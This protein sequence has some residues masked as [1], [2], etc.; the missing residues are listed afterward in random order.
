ML[1][2]GNE[3]ISLS[4]LV[5]ALSKTEKD[6]SW[7]CWVTEK[8]TRSI[9][10][11]TNEEYQSQPLRFWGKTYQKLSLGELAALAHT[12]ID[13]EIDLN[14]VNF[15]MLFLNKTKVVQ[16]LNELRNHAIEKRNLPSLVNLTVPEEGLH[17]KKGKIK[18]AASDLKIILHKIWYWFFDPI[19][20]IS[21][22]SK[23]SNRDLVDKNYFNSLYCEVVGGFE[24]SEEAAQFEENGIS[25]QELKKCTNHFSIES[26]NQ[27]KDILGVLKN[28]AGAKKL[29]TAKISDVLTKVT[30]LQEEY[31][32]NIQELNNE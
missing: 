16:R 20:K 27:I 7:V 8:G 32:K 15:K 13:K 2:L 12:F 17:E 28:Q 25:L 9:R 26:V 6:H 1:P 31:N 11:L 24:I 22:L 29:S 4:G 21:N 10:L 14:S 19:N 18:S 30:R 3:I 5:D 23:L